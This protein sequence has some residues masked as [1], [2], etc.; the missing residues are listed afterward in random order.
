VILAL[1]LVVVMLVAVMAIWAMG[2]AVLN[3]ILR[4]IAHFRHFDFE[5]QVL[6]SQGMVSIQS[7]HGI[8]HSD[9]GEDGR[10]FTIRTT[11]S[12]LVA[13]FQSF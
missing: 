6:S 11:S 4:G 3:F 9:Y 2:M 12:E 7:H 5:G 8:R 1:I 10:G 13:D